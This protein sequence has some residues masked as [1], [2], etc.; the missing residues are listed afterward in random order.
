MFVDG[1]GEMISL[2]PLRDVVH[3]LELLRGA[4]AHSIPIILC[5]PMP[6]LRSMSVLVQGKQGVRPLA[7]VTKAGVIITRRIWGI[8]PQGPLQG[9]WSLEGVIESMLVG[10]RGLVE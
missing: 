2:G 7:A 3:S 9:A 8:C 10:L 1:V 5:H 6:P 4:Q